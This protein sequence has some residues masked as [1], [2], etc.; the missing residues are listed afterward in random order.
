MD[1]PLGDPARTTRDRD[2]PSL[3]HVSIP[4]I[5]RAEFLRLKAAM[6]GC[7]FESAFD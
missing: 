1:P 2:L 6:P 4:E 5:S 3:R 7:T